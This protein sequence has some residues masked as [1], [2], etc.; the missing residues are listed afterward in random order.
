MLENLNSSIWYI[1]VRAAG[2]WRWPCRLI[3]LRSFSACGHLMR[4]WRVLRQVSFQVM[5]DGKL[6]NFK[7]KMCSRNAE[8]LAAYLTRQLLY[9]CFFGL[10]IIEA[11]LNHLWL[12][13][14]I[15]RVKQELLSHRCSNKIKKN[16]MW[17]GEKKEHLREEYF[18]SI[19]R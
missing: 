9:Y 5:F 14:T 4:A 10:S 7:F 2:C 8:L 15:C 3:C 16:A 1:R 17:L 12:I 11:V 19:L 13:Q 18:N 6:Y